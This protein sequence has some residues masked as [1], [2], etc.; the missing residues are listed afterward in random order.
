[1]CDREV[2]VLLIAVAAV[3]FEYNRSSKKSAEKEEYIKEQFRRIEQ[4]VEEQN[5]VCLLVSML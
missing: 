3:L 2:F 1:L 4:I 5:R